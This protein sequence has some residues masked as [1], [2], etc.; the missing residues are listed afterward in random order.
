MIGAAYPGQLYPGEYPVIYGAGSPTNYTALLNTGSYSVSGQGVVVGVS[1]GA[2]LNAGSYLVA[3]QVLGVLVSYNVSL[4]VGSYALSGQA[5]TANYVGKMNYVAALNTGS[6]TLNGQV[7]T[8]S[9]VSNI[10]AAQQG[11]SGKS[12]FGEQQRLSRQLD[13]L[14]ALEDDVIINL[15]TSAVVHE[16]LCCT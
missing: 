12:Y 1:R 8:G 5:I 6:Y 14:I 2:A 3:G 16:M 7:I 9:Y 10:P 11:G 13:E 4:S 15:L